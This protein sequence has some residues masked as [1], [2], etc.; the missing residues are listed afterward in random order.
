MSFKLNVFTGT[1]DIAGLSKVVADTYYL[2]LDQSTPQSVIN[3]SP[4]F[5]E[6]ITIKAGQKIIYDGA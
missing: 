5:Q 1:F 4:K 3:G 2:K 6:G